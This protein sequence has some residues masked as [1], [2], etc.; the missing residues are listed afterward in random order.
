MNSRLIAPCGMNCAICIGHLRDKNKCLG[1]REMG[2]GKPKQCRKCAIIQCK[3]LKENKM[4]FCSDKCEKFPCTR[5][6]N[7]DKRYKAKYEM[8][9]L[10]NLGH[11]I[12]FGIRRFVKAEQ[13]RWNCPECEEL[14]CVHRNR[15]LKCG[16]KR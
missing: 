15:C 1:C 8:S 7:L 12:N 2:E 9:M 4:V 16:A 6:K 11:I 3:I 5:L 14:L 10:E 13:K